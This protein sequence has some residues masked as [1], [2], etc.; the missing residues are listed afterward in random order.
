MNEPILRARLREARRAAGLTQARAAKAMGGRP[1][2]FMSKLESGE[3]QA[4]FAE[5]V[6]L[7]RIY[8]VPITYLADA[9]TGEPAFPIADR[10][11]I[12]HDNAQ[13]EAAYT[14]VDAM[15]EEDR[16]RR[17]KDLPW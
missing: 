9:V 1:Q 17:R 7:A 10:G 13:A 15:P 3:R 5:V 8:G 16:P 14:E 4:R 12:A 2:S 11:E 6:R